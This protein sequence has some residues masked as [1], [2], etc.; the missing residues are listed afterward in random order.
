[1]SPYFSEVFWEVLWPVSRLIEYLR[2]EDVKLD[3]GLGNGEDHNPS[4]KCARIKDGGVGEW[5][6]PAVLKFARLSRFLNKSITYDTY[7]YSDLACFGRSWQ[8]NVQQNVQ[9]PEFCATGL[10]APSLVAN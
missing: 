3:Y 2:R 6:K 8:Q 10:L 9:R 7:Q 5:L 4:N 1:M